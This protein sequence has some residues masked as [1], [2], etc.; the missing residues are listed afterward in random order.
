[1]ATMTKECDVTLRKLTQELPARSGSVAELVTA[2]VLV[3]VLH[4]PK[5]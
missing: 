2:L 1:M 4:C 5:G 3:P